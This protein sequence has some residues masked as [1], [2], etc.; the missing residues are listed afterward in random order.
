MLEK[1]TPPSSDVTQSVVHFIKDNGREEVEVYATR[2]MRS[3]TGHELR[4]EE[5]GAV[6]L[7]SNTSCRDMYENYC[8]DRG[9]TPK[10]DNKGRYPKVSEYPNLKNDDMLWET[11]VEV[12]D[13]CSCWCSVSSGRSTVLLPGLKD[14][15]MT[16]MESA[17]CKRIH[18]A[19]ARIARGK[20]KS[21][22][23]PATLMAMMICLV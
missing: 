9:W 4:D 18:S 23:M 16:L 11:D 20:F 12:L 13:V 15:E 6:D 22:T 7:P 1:L 21:K 8:F 3:L 10:S 2:I 19:T 5:K 17:K 14:L